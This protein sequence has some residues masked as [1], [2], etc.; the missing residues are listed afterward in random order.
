MVESDPR[1]TDE[2]LTEWEK[3]YDL[4]DDCFVPGKS[5]QQRKN[6]IFARLITVGQQD[7]G[8]FIDLAKSLGFTVTITEFKPFW[9][10]VGA[11]GDG[12][13]ELINIFYWQIN[14]NV[15]NGGAFGRSFSTG[16]DTSE[17]DLEAMQCYLTKLK[18]AHTQLLFKQIGP[19]FSK[20]FSSAYDSE[21]SGSDANLQGAFDK[22]F[23]QGYNV[24]NG[25]AYDNSF[26]I[27]FNKSN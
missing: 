18:P 25:G 21:D 6:D 10:N 14:Y 26:G 7:K 16:F 2:L 22:S 8:Y 12:I 11:M 3:E 13:G 15:V 24:A 5:I 9:M 27:G 17:N 19:A 23:G 1:T 20:A 4:P